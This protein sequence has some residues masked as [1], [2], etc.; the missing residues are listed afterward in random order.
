MCRL[1]LAISGDSTCTDTLVATKLNEKACVTDNDLHDV[2]T[3]GTVSWNAIQCRHSQ[4]CL[5]SRNV[6]TSTAAAN[7]T[8]GVLCSTWGWKDK[9]APATREFWM[10]AFA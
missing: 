7:A 9:L 10:L 1:A 4:L 2:S 8:S 6:S 3:G 5:A